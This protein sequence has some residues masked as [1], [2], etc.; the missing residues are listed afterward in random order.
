MLNCVI[1]LHLS[2]LFYCRTTRTSLTQASLNRF[3]CEDRWLRANASLARH[4]W[5]WV[6]V[7]ACAC[8][9]VCVC[10]CVCVYRFVAISRVTPPVETPWTRRSPGRPD[11]SILRMKSRETCVMMRF[12]R[13]RRG[14]VT[15]IV[16]PVRN[17]MYRA[18]RELRLE[19]YSCV[20]VGFGEPPLARSQ[21]SFSF[22][23]RGCETSERGSGE[24]GWERGIAT[25]I[26]WDAHRACSGL[27]RTSAPVTHPR[28]PN[29]K[30][31][32]VTRT[33]T[34]IPG[35]S[36]GLDFWWASR[37]IKELTSSRFEN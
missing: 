8:L 4:P 29:R 19:M 27:L 10:V 23:R 26:L 20:W 13:E 9:C 30:I 28:A 3:D 18:L 7:R 34:N 5:P 12:N 31:S 17:W 1:F 37:T 11:S 2:R 25:T 6:C 16:A 15:S 24:R 22:S 32:S 21:S 33:R 36:P 14:R 35:I